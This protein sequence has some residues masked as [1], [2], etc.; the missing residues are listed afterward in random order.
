L[1]NISPAWTVTKGATPKTVQADGSKI[2]YNANSVGRATM[3][4][5]NTDDA[6][7]NFFAN[8]DEVEIKIGAQLMLVG[9]IDDIIDTRLKNR[10]KELQLEITDFGGYLAAKTAFE[11]DFK[12]STLPDT[13]LET[14][15][16]EISGLTTN[17]TGLN[18]VADKIKRNFV[19]TYVK[20]G[21]NA[22]VTNVGADYFTDE[23]KVFQAFPEGTRELQISSN[24]IK[25]VDGTPSGSNQFTPDYGQLNYNQISIR[26]LKTNQ[27][28]RYT[29]EPI[30]WMRD[31]Q[32]NNESLRADHQTINVEEL[33]IK[34]LH[35]ATGLEDTKLRT[36]DRRTF[37]IL[38]TKW[39][40]LND[41]DPASFLE[42]TKPEKKD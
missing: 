24:T 6:L 32:L 27:Y 3:I 1:S 7:N 29:F 19:G 5:D 26:D 39:L 40:A 10:K 41:V 17:V 14:M 11:R 4:F 23:S 42:D 28:T 16:A 25:I 37:Q 31:Q 13:I 12:R 36:M 15:A 9:F 22:V 35:E 34:R 30:T 18:V 20:D 33:W 8:E 38:L 2:V 21:W